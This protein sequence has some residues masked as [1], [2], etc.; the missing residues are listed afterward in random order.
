MKFTFWFAEKGYERALAPALMSGAAAHGDEIVL[1]PNADYAGP[2]GDGGIICGVT[3]REVLWDHRAK[4]V[5]L[6]YID[7]GFTRSR[8]EYQGHNLPEW[9]RMCVNATHPTEYLMRVNRPSDRR[10]RMRVAFAKRRA[11][12]KIVI[13]GSSGKFHL[14]H[15]LTEPTEWTRDL[16]GVI[17]DFSDRAIIY[18]PKPSWKY[19]VPIA[20]ARFDHGSKT[21]VDSVLTDAWCAITYGSIAS[22]DSI[23]AGVPCI[24]LGNAVAA[25]ISS[26]SPADI[27]NP[28]W[29]DLAQREQWLANLAYCHWRP[30]EIASGL[31][32][33]IIREIIDATV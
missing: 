10:Q 14:T 12:H 19:A 9:W 13:L 20:G 18:R 16:I 11:G 6:I 3:K 32:W 33:K 8:A 22:V 29:A 24:V 2:E 21:P 31:A 1:K 5:P 4:H 7:K 26:H 25:P 30:A 23:L 27:E 28:L 17:R 15:H